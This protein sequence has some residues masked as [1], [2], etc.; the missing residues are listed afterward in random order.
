MSWW[1][2][3]IFFLILIFES[4]FLLGQS[5]LQKSVDYILAIREPAI[6]MG[7]S[8]R[9]FSEDSVGVKTFLYKTE[10]ATVWDTIASSGNP[11][12]FNVDIG[13]LLNG[14]EYQY[15]VLFRGDLS[16]IVTSRQDDEPPVVNLLLNGNFANQNIIQ[17][18]FSTYDLI[19]QSVK[20]ASLY[21]RPSHNVDAPWRLVSE[22]QLDSSMVAAVTDPLIDSMVFI[23][24]DTLGD[25]AYEFFVAARDTA[26]APDHRT[27]QPFSGIEGN[28]LSPANSTPALKQIY[29]DTHEPTSSITS[30]LNRILNN[31]V[32][33]I[34]YLA[35]DSTF[36]HD[37]YLGSGIEKTALYM[38]YKTD[39]SGAFIFQ[40][41]LYESQSFSTPLLVVN[42]AYNFVAEK[43]GYYEFYTLSA[44]TAQNK[45]NNW[46][47][48]TTGLPFVFV[49]TSPPEI[50]RVT[51]IENIMGSEHPAKPGWTK[52]QLIG[53]NAFGVEDV[54][55]DGYESGVDSFF[56]AENFDFDLNVKSLPAQTG[57]FEYSSFGFY[58]V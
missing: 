4:S 52:E 42:G 27:D 45:E 48:K 8:N 46:S 14:V 30:Q 11:N 10:A 43:N 26:W 16:N 17:I 22:K 29:V 13:G 36:G 33:S 53:Y 31:A 20:R 47:P 34:E 24:R 25:G 57:T 5:Q 7:T 39:F 23:V 18:P 58:L 21:Y 40:D 38:N 54:L 55:T 35:Q 6:T 3:S 28:F 44:D 1:K 32:F 37:G 15:R 9:V 12:Q 2:S 49:D 51:V 41:S 56:L 50:D 19:S